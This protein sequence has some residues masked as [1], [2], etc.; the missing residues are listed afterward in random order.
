M[1]GDVLPDCHGNGEPAFAADLPVAAVDFH[2]ARLVTALVGDVP[3]VAMKPIAEHLGLNWSG[4]H[5]RIRR[6]PVLMRSICILHM[7]SSRGERDAVALPIGLISGW[8]FGVKVN[9]VK[10]HLRDLLITYQA[11]C[12]AVLD[13]YWR[14][15]VAVNPRVHD[16]PDDQPWSTT[17]DGRTRG[18]RFAEERARWETR[19]ARTLVGVLD[20]TKS[21]LRAME[22]F[23]AAL[24]KPGALENLMILGF[25]IRFIY[26]GERTMTDAELAVRDAYRLGSDEERSA[27]RRHAEAV[28][29]RRAPQA[30]AQFDSMSGRYA[31]ADTVRYITSES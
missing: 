2:G 8:L 23:D 31:G 11:E 13:A 9:M 12:F 16:V 18:Q 15:G 26:H 6:H 17:G 4:Q 14:G 21:K 25:D 3:H 22:E 7:E 19:T 24:T 30:P 28:R 27:I 5:Q 10:P 1:V 20:F 29:I